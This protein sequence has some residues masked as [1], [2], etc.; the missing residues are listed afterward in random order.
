MCAGTSICAPRFAAARVSGDDLR[1][2]EDAHAVEGGEYGERAAHMSVR[3][4]V[5]VQIEAHV[6]GFV[7]AHL[8]ALLTRE[9][10]LG[11]GEKMRLFFSEDLAYPSL[12]L[13]RTQPLGG[14]PLAPGVGLRVQIVEITEAARRAKNASR[15]KRI[16]RSTRPFSLPRATATGRGWKR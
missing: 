8:D 2:I 5:V 16:A 1:A 6:R 11:Q 3:D 4:G 13:R 10:V 9:R 15:A 14:G 12:A 7:R